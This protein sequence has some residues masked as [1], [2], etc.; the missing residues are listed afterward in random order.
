MTDEDEKMFPEEEIPETGDEHSETG[1]NNENPAENYTPW[2][3]FVEQY[4]KY[5]TEK[6]PQSV[7][8]AVQKGENPIVGYLLGENER[9]GKEIQMMRAEDMLRRSSVG[10][11]SST[12]AE[13]AGDD[14][15]AGLLYGG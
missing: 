14:F 8:D 6:L 7:I 1:E 12:K 4:P 5:M 15:A 2:L 9:L 13:K 10:G 3:E 11:A